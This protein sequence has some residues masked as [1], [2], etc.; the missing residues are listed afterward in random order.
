MSENETKTNK[1]AGRCERCGSKVPAGEGIYVSGVDLGDRL[2]SRGA[3]HRTE[4]E[5]KKTTKT[6]KTFTNRVRHFERIAA[7]DAVWEAEGWKR[8]VSG[9][10]QHPSYG[11]GSG[12]RIVFSASWGEGDRVITVSTAAG[13]A[14]VPYPALKTIPDF[15]PEREVAMVGIVKEALA[16]IGG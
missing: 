6:Y 13:T 4:D 2:M 5:C 10:V 11:G 7:L 16:T 1:Y 14:V 15:G 8:P 3:L 12:V 9:H